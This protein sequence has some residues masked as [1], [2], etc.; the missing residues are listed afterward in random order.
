MDK[1][2]EQQLKDWLESDRNSI[3]LGDEGNERILY[4]SQINDDFILLYYKNTS[5]DDFIGLTSDLVNSGIYY[6]R[7]G[8]IYNPGY[9]L[10]LMCEES[11]IIKA[12]SATADITE[13]LSLAVREY[14]ESI[15]NSNTENFSQGKITSERELNDLSYFTNYTAKDCARVLFLA[16]KN[17]SDIA[18]KCKGKIG[19]FSN[20][21]Y[22]EFIT[23]KDSLI[24]AKGD[25]FIAENKKGILLQLKENSA[26]A[27]ELQKIYD[28]PEHEL[29]RIKAIINAVKE[30]GAKTVNVTIN[31]DN[32]DFTFKYNADNLCRDPNGYYKNWGMKSSDEKDFEYFF[33]R[34][35]KF[36][37]SD[38]TQISYCRNIIYD[39]SEFDMTETEDESMIQSM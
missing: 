33:G 10:K 21:N 30:S 34:G 16:D 23:N 12:K 25:N 37:A 27:E 17:I 38:I 26:I 11:P 8:C 2:T 14:V 32:K 20:N 3:S 36:Y 22:L 7:D 35:A 9:Y 19:P 4:K 5:K 29:F 28:D 31:K 18:Y 1:L 24:K 15:V 39:S 6:K 13:Q